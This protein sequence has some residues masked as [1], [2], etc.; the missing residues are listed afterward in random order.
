MISYSDFVRLLH[1]V[2]ECNSPEEY[3]AEVGGSVPLGDPCK[4]I[5]LLGIMWEMAHD[6]LTIR[7]IATAC[8]TSMRQIGIKLGISR[9]TIGNWSEGVTSPPEWQ[10]PLI[11]Y[12][13]VSD[14][15]QDWCNCFE[16]D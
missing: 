7:S 16:K 3:I 4:I 11:A 10:L 1:D 8:K 5:E 13:A 12:A 9:R 2:S 14:Y 6:G 15:R